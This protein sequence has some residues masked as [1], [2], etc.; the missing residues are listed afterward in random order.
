ML[1]VLEK[2]LDF[3]GGD[4]VSDI[5]PLESLLWTSPTIFPSATAGRRY[6]RGSRRRRSGFAGRARGSRSWCIR[7]ARRCPGDGDLL[8]ADR[9]SVD[10]HRLLTPGCRRPEAAAG[11]PRKRPAFPRGERPDRA[12]SRWRSLWPARA[13]WFGRL[14]EDLAGV[15]DHVGV[16]QDS[17]AL[18]DAPEP[19]VSSG[20]ALVHG[21]R[22]RAG[23]W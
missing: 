9:I 22:S 1:A 13:R 11:G 16:G 3:A 20:F 12:P 23:G 15:R 17:I 2:P 14:D 6:C 8:A 7:S 21:G 19:P 18:D 5:S 4:K 10:A